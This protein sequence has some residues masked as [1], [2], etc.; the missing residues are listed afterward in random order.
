D[1]NNWLQK[2]KSFYNTD[3][4]NNYGEIA[5]F[6]VTQ[7]HDNR[8][9]IPIK[10]FDQEVACL[11]DSG[12]TTTVI[13]RD[14]LRFIKALKLFAPPYKMKFIV[15]ADGSKRRVSGAVDLPLYLHD[16]FHIIKAL[17]V[18]SLHHE[19]ILGSDFCRN[20]QLKIDFKNNKWEVQDS[21][22]I[23][24]YPQWKVIENLVYKFVPSKLP[25]KSNIREWK[26]L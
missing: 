4:G 16:Q 7:H 23:L 9:Y 26:L 15:T 25:F 14:G 6:F 22:K 1:W 24:M 3:R 10:I 13:G 17:V 8:P 21:N 2:V 19:I 5:P 20:F 18:P 11:L 12:A